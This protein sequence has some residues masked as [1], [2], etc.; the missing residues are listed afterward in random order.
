MVPRRNKAARLSAVAAAGLALAACGAGEP[1]PAPTQPSIT[2]GLSTSLPIFWPE[3]TDPAELLAKDLRLPWPRAVIERQHR[4]VPLNTLAGG[5][6]LDGVDAVM[7]VQPRPLT[8][9]ENVALDRWV[10][11]GGHALVFADPMLTEDSRFGLGD[12]RRPQDVALLSPILSRWGLELL[13][14][15]ADPD[16]ER[17]IED[18]LAGGVPVHLPGRLRAI[19]G[20]GEAADQ[21]TTGAGALIARCRIGRGKVTVVADA[22]LF[23]HA[24][25][26]PDAVREAAL[27]RLVDSLAIDAVGTSGASRGNGGQARESGGGLPAETG[28]K[29]YD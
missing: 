8:P 22:A 29:G 27:E 19:E 5:G 28:A 9:G 1:D 12:K 13:V 21:C 20:T 24:S 4:L 16:G 3:A 18:P 17:V 15:D 26:S 6:A 11:D 25:E 10:R 7:L 14:D 23:E 2:I